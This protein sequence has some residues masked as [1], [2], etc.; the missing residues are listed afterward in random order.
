MARGTVVGEGVVSQ[1]N[2]QEFEEGYER[3]FGPAK[4][5]ER[6][7]WIWDESQQKLVRA[8]DYVPPV[9]AINAPVCS[10]RLY[11]NVGTAHDG[12]PINS[13][14]DYREYQ[15]RTG[16]TQIGDFKD[17]WAKAQKERE[18]HRQGGTEKDRRER[19]EALI[20]ATHRR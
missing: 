16:V 19:R 8:E 15:K 11:E 14:K 20:A 9:L 1:A 2:T 4:K 3:T 10:G 7:R 5:V 12:T 17:T 13:R 18:Q 6:G